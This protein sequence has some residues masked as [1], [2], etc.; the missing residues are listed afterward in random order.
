MFALIL[1]RLFFCSL[2]NKSLLRTI[3]C[4]VTFHLMCIFNIDPDLCENEIFVFFSFTR[5]FQYMAALVRINEFQV[6]AA[7]CVLDAHALTQ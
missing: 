1:C 4:I 5:K 2:V 3:F 7:S 6:F